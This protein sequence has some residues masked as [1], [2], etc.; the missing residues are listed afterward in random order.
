M[1]SGHFILGDH[2]PQ[3]KRKWQNPMFEKTVQFSA[4]IMAYNTTD[5]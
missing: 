2:L 3:T 4:L 5:M 1:T